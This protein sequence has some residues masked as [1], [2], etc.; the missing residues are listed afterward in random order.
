MPIQVDDTT[1]EDILRKIDEDI[2][3][4]DNYYTEEI[5][6]KVIERYEIYYA[7]QKYYEKKFPKISKASSVVSCDVADTL[8]WA[9]PAIMKVFFGSEDVITIKGI[10]SDD[11]DQADKMQELINFQLRKNKAFEVFYNWFKDAL[12]TGCGV[13]KCYWEREVKSDTRTEVIG[14]EQL[15]VLKTVPQIQ[16]E[17]IDQVASDLFNV[18]YTIS[19]IIKNMPKI[20]NLLLSE[21]RFSPNCRFLAEAPFVAHKKRVTLDYLR[22]K[23]IE[24]MYEPGT[25]D[26]V[27]ENM[28]TPS[29][30]EL[31]EYTRDYYSVNHNNTVEEAR[32]ECDLYECYTQLDINGD[33]L[34]ENLIITKVEGVILR[35]EDNIYGRAPFFLL[36]PEKDPHRI[37]PKKSY[38]E[39]I[40]EL[41]HLKVALHKQ[42]M[43]NTSLSNDGKMIVS[44]EAVNIDDIINGRSIIRKKAGFN[45]SDVIQP[46]PVVPLASWTFNYLE[47]IEEQKAERTGVTRYT[48]GQDSKGLNKTATG[49][50]AIMSASNQRLEMICRMFSE[51]ALQELFRFLIELNQ[52]FM[53]STTVIR[54]TGEPMRITMDDI[55]GEMDLIVN[56]AVGMGTK[57]MT[58]MN[59]Q[60]MLT[61]MM[62]LSS[63]PMGALIVSPMNIYNIV[64]KYVEELGFKNKDAYV[65][66]PVI[67]MQQIQMQNALNGG[68]NGQL[69]DP[70]GNPTGT[71]SPGGQGIH[72]QVSPGVQAM[73]TAPTSNVQNGGYNPTQG[74]LPRS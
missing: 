37:M 55:S 74:Y 8:N 57:E 29:D 66:N 58:L 28:K 40:A 26:K 10:T 44:E 68:I 20:E 45:M 13:I 63:T 38:S 11:V 23:E 41:Q 46:M 42:I 18:T 19:H 14:L 24:G 51:T 2:Q 73:G 35:V 62:Q 59:L 1:K 71:E 17:R 54:I 48:Q 52:K 16:I 49:I 69:T 60:T 27:I 50:S 34:L 15:A 61:T 5:E 9:I 39:M 21:L 32:K 31:D 33:G 30:T 72:G 6:P 70:N 22:R 47:Y 56:S 7:D 65:T 12:I 43:I 3:I 4:A 36:S 64:A 67:T 53:D 25:V